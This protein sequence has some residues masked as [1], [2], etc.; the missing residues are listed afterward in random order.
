MIPSFIA[1]DLMDM[2]LL[3]GYL[4][5][6]L[7]ATALLLNYIIKVLRKQR[8]VFFELLL[9]LHVCICEVICNITT[10]LVLLLQNLTIN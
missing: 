4:I 8:I 3:C 7:V 5:L 9:I 1:S 2:I 10:I 6:A